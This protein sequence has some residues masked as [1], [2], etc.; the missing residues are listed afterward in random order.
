M[1]AYYNARAPYMAKSLATP[2]AGQLL[3]IVTE[4]EKLARGRTVLEIAC[5][6]GYWTR[7]AAPGSIGTLATDASH[8]MLGVARSLGIANARF[9]HDDAYALASLG[10]ARFEFGFAMHWVSHVPMARW[11]EFFR[12][13]HRH[14]SPGARVLLADDIRRPD[15]ADIYYSKLDSRDSFEIR[16]LPNG[17][18]YEIVKHFFSPQDLR[19]RLEPYGD[20]IEIQFERPRWWLT[21]E[22][23]R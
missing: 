1:R 18:S 16:E 7:F 6:T 8:E 19:A 17:E 9:A 5:G 22:V 4:L 23:K 20:R 3:E 11:D 12:S 13:F 21:Y 15:D 2:P 10:D 14:L